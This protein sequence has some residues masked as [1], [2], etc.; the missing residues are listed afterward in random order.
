MRSRPPGRD[1][2]IV[3]APPPSGYSGTPLPKKLGLRDGMVALFVGLPPDL[4][5]LAGAAA[6]GAVDTAGDIALIGDGA[7]RDYIHLFTTSAAELA[8]AT[9]L[10]RAG[11]KPDG[12]AW[13]SWPKKAS[14][15]PTD[16]TED[17]IR[18][19]MLPSGLVDVKVAAVDEVWSGLKLVI[20]KELRT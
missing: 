17:R 8:A 14:K 15:R 4:A 5:S 3:S 1:P 10:I 9:P 20:R 18:D 7:K 13:I 6:F 12:M 16:I 19:I 11:L 2:G